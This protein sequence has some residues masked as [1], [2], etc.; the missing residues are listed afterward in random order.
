MPRRRFSSLILMFACVSPLFLNSCATPKA[1]RAAIAPASPRAPDVHPASLPTPPGQIRQ[2]HIQELAISQDDLTQY[3]ALA[4]PRVGLGLSQ[5]LVRVLMATH[6]FDLMGPPSE[7]AQHLSQ[8]WGPS[9]E[10]INMQATLDKSRMPTVFALSAKLFDISTC[11]PVSRLA[12]AQQQ[13]S[14]RSSVGVQVRIEAPSGQ[15]VPGATHPL[16]PQSRHIHAEDLPILGTSEIA[17][18]QSALGM[19]AAKAVQYALLQA[20][21]RLDRL[22]W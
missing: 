6:R 17:F 19:T 13:A 1:S 18:S 8:T 20:I 7:L 15:F 22:G 16:A 3:P 4:A 10:G 9:P 12:S 5:L 11:Q 2:L 14:Y 21:E